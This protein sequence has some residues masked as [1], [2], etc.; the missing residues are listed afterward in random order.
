M[1]IRLKNTILGIDL[2]FGE[3]ETPEPISPS[4]D[5][6]Q[7]HPRRY[8][9]Y[10]HV[11]NSGEYF[12]V[13]KG[14]ARRAWSKDR[15]PIWHR[16]VDKHL[17]GSYSVKILIDDL[18]PDEAEEVEAEFIAQ[19]SDTLVNWFNTGRKIDFD[20]NRKYHELR[21]ANRALIEKS[22][23]IEKSDLAQAAE[24]YEDAISKIQEYAFIQFESGVVGD[25]LK[26]ETDEE[27]YSGELEA[28]DRITLCLT[29]LGNAQKAAKVTE[30]YFT[31]Y[32]ADL[33]L[34]TAERIQKRVKKALAKNS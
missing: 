26:E 32:R 7:Q 31:T 34:K 17:N 20:A 30:E 15:H 33:C 16:Y 29:K 12:Y 14:K 25:L 5:A 2:S 22:K 13:G 3:D 8:Y 1:K 9:I 21:N 4:T 10:A 19:H 28:L 23:L 27:G 6:D 24:M 11:D 18:D